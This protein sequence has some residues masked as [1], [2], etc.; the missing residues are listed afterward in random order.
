MYFSSAE[1]WNLRDLHMF[2]TL[3]R[4]LDHKGEEAKAVIWAHNSH[5]GDARATAMG[6][7]RSELNLGQLARQTF[8]SQVVSLGCGTYTGTVAAAHE[9]DADMKIMNVLPS[10]PDSY[11][12]LAHQ[13]GIESFFLDL[14]EGKCDE[15]LR[16]E[17]MKKRL[18]RFIGAIY[19]PET[20]R[21][22]HYC[23]AILP[24]QFDGYIWFDETNSVKALEIHQPNTPLELDETYPYGM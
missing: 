5:L 14:R 8:G 1:S 12:Y 23:H 10:L 24:K 19:R 20:E 21:E 4:V 7:H 18:E 9:W 2:Q 16:Q 22:S 3:K 11:E 17:L 15:K 13:T 6:W